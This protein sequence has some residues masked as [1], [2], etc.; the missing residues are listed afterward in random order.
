MSS[1][2]RTFHPQTPEK[3]KSSIRHVS[4][5]TPDVL[6]DTQSP[7]LEYVDASSYTSRREGSDTDVEWD[8][9]TSGDNTSDD[10]TLNYVDSINSF[11][12]RTPKT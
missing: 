10:N 7:F 3:I 4:P 2:A 6:E 11:G 1:Q 8:E 9:S 12:C 5:D